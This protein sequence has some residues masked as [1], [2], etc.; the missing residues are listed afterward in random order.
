MTA[1][2]SAHIGLASLPVCLTVILVKHGEHLVAKAI[3]QL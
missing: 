1:G 3:H 2:D